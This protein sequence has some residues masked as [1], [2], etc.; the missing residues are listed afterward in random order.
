MPTT[1]KEIIERHN[2]SI[3]EKVQW[4]QTVNSTSE[5][6]YVVAIASNEEELTC[7]DDAPLCEQEISNWIK[8]VN[9]NGLNIMVD[10]CIA[11]TQKLRQ[12]LSGFWYADETILYIGKVESGSSNRNLRKRVFEYYETKLGCSRKHSGGNW[13]NT[14]TILPELYVYCSTCQNP[15][16]IEEEMIT[17]F[18]V[19]VSNQSRQMLYDKEHCYPFA[20][21][22]LNKSQRKKHGITNQTVDCG[23]NWRRWI[24]QL[25]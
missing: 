25:G 13:V 4:G 22:E 1:V 20:N 8:L 9:N 14:L 10:K 11:S 19:N 21:K 18:Q 3:T 6:I 7:I 24:W 12:R 17:Y 23:R 5:G 16:L 2:L 15:A